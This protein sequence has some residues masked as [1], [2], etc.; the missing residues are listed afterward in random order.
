MVEGAKSFNTVALAVASTA[1]TNQTHSISISCS[2]K[3]PKLQIQNKHKQLR[4]EMRTHKVTY[5][6]YELG[7]CN[8]ISEGVIEVQTSSAYTAEQTVKAMFAGLEVI[9]RSTN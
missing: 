4:W 2:L 8:V 6:A 7:T 9:V 1:R 5:T 3:Q